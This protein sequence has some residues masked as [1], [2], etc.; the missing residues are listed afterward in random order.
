MI[1]KKKPKIQ[2]EI[3]DGKEIIF[4]GICKRGNINLIIQVRQSI[5]VLLVIIDVSCVTVYLFSVFY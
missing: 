4:T 5:N 3:R 2:K 1:E